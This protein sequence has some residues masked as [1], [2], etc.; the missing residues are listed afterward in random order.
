MGEKDN[1]ILSRLEKGED[2]SLSDY[3]QHCLYDPQ[4]GYYRNARSLGQGGDFV[5]SPDISQVFGETLG[6]WILDLW[7]RCGEPKSFTILELGGGRGTAMRD[8][9]SLLKRSPLFSGL[10]II[11]IELNPHFQKLQKH[12]LAEFQDK[13]TWVENFDS[14][15]T[16]VHGIIA[17]EFL[18][19]LPIQQFVFHNDK[20]HERRIKMEKNKLQFCLKEIATL[21]CELPDAKPTENDVLEYAPNLKNLMQKI[22]QLTCAALLIDY[23][24]ATPAYG[25]SL[26]AVH[27][28]KYASVLEM[29]DMP[30]LSAHVNFHA[31]ASFSSLTCAPLLTQHEF[32]GSMGGALRLQKLLQQAKGQTQKQSL[33]KAY[34]RISDPENMGGLFKVLMLYEESL[35]Q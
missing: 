6:F 21:P 17:N 14:I 32:I 16:K 18:D 3:M 5:T 33:T 25:D 12:I 24:Y 13:I 9:L 11:M 35:A 27:K 2:I 7:Q 29:D 26:Q 8:I 10:K 4:D 19:C 31:V 1:H 23:G 15:K 30:D 20:W 34:E 22:S 28:Q